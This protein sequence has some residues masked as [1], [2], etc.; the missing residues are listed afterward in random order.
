M[1]AV[2][3]IQRICS[4]LQNAQSI[5]ALL[6]W[7]EFSITS[8]NVAS[9]LARQGVL[10]GTVLDVGANVGQFAVASAKLFPN[11]EIHSFEPVPACAKRLR[12]NVSGLENVTVYPFAL[13]DREGEVTFRVNSDDQQSSILP[14]AQVRRDAFPDARETQ[15]LKMKISTLD[16]VF[17]DIEFR[18]PVLLKLDVQGYEAQTICGGTETLKRVSYV[19]LEASF[20]P[21]YEGELPFINLVQMMEEHSFRFERPMSCYA[22]PGSDEIIEMDALFVRD[23]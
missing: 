7:P 2:N 12:K 1:R 20:E 16:Q 17:R 8:F 3:K 5:K 9:G 18:L 11:V 19:V 14:F 21:T 13:G 23:V 10:P 6:T 22:I 15:M 4:L